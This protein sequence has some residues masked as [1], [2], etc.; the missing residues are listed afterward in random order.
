M[1]DP[2]TFPDPDTPRPDR[3]VDDYLHLG[4][5]QHPCAGRGIN[6]WQI[7]MLVAGLLHCRPTSLG[8]MTW[9]GPFPALLPVHC[10]GGAA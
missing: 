7:P 9:A 1:F 4:G 10:Q 5:G 6:A 3:P 2:T 8:P